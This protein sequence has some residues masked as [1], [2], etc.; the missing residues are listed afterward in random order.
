MVGKISSGQTYQL[1]AANAGGEVIGTVPPGLPAFSIPEIDYHIIGHLLPFAVIISLLGFQQKFVDKLLSYSLQ[2]DNVLYCMDNETS[3]TSEWGKFWATYIKK[4]AAEEGKVELLAFDLIEH[5]KILSQPDADPDELIHAALEKFVSR[6]DWQ[7]DTF[8]IGVPGE[9]L[10]DQVMYCGTHS[11]RDVDKF[12]EWMKG[13]VDRGLHEK[14]KILAG[15]APIKSVRMAQDLKNSVPG[16]DLPDEVIKR[17]REAGEGNAAREGIKI[18]VETIEELK[19]TEG[20]AGV[21][22]TAI[23]WE[24]KVPEM[25]KETGLFPRPQL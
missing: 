8:V 19:E 16:M 18:C 20:V 17:L 10:A 15:G 12:R 9:S 14:V 6:N 22:I 24:E 23:E 1:T 11:G 7:G 2:F 13:V 25:V 21:H 3:V 5:P 4:R